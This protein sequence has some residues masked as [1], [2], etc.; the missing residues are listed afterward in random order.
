MSKAQKLITAFTN[1]IRNDRSS[2]SMSTAMCQTRSN[3]SQNRCQHLVEKTTR[4][5]NECLHK[6]REITKLIVIS[7][8]CIDVHEV[9][10]LLRYYA[11]YSGNST[12][13]CRYRII[14]VRCVIGLK[15][16]DLTKLPFI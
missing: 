1:Q 12:P 5:S 15:R 6:K 7:G 10:T 11:P 16:T 14:T 3:T 2:Y 8:F 4:K 9:C 13:K